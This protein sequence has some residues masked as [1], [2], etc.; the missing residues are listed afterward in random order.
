MSRPKKMLPVLGQT[1]APEQETPGATS[2]ETDSCTDDCC[3]ESEALPTARE[4]NPEVPGG[5]FVGDDFQRTVVRVEGMDCASCAATVEKRV[6]ALPGV[7]RATVN[8]A[9]GR[10]DA[11]HDPGLPMEEIEEAVE[12]AGYRVVRAEGAES[13]PFWRTRRAALTGASAVLF[14]IGLA[15][16]LAGTS[17][18]LATGTYATAILVGGLPIFRAALA[19][20]RARQLDMNVLMG[21]ATI[22]AAGIGEWAEAASVVVLFSAG[23]ALQAYAVD[24]TRGAVRSLA[25]LA[26][27]EVLVRRGDGEV[28]VAADEVGVGEVV[29]VRPGERLAVDG[30]VIEGESAMDESPVTGEGVP[31]E[32]GPGAGVYSGALNGSGGLIVGATKRAGDSTLQRISRL[33]EEAQA[34]KAP[35]EQFVDRFSRVY[36]PIVVAVAVVLAV[37]PPLLGGGFGEWFYRALALL[38]I[39]CPCALVISTPVTVVAGI[40]AASRRGILVKG[41]AALEAAGRLGALA[42]DKTGTL[43]E[44]RPVLS[45]V[46]ALEG[47]EGEALALAAALER[48]SEHPLAYAILSAAEDRGGILPSVTGFRSF[49]G[50]GAT[51]RVDDGSYLIGSPRLFAER[52]VLLGGAAAAL[53][54]V[55][56]AG[57]TPVV[58]GVEEGG[59]IAVFGLADAVRPDARA[60]VEALRDSGIGEIVMLTGDAE[61]PARRVAESVGVDY[62]ARLLPE[63]KVEAVRGLVEKHGSAGMV[64]DGVND[65]PALAASSVGFAMG[66]AGTDVALETADVALMRD[67]LPKLAEAVRL[68]RAAEGIIKQNVLVSLLVKGMFVLLAPFGL[69]ALWAAVLADMGTSIAVTLNGLRLFKKRT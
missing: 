18:V 38:I 48:R 60:T 23:N 67:D 6:F 62:R 44:G 13:A 42:L 57:E 32:K 21:A 66:A 26:P 29:I 19:G 1:P 59:P 14:L 16:S 43:T 33:V 47:S 65:A 55:E 46:V 20:L 15:L 8:F 41:G 54:E 56:R 53:E 25:R 30:V 27:D 5:V 39:A 63:Q 51:G 52:E 68:S 9:A 61:A 40:G 64:G 69:V 4:A 34:E 22:G 31:V 12:G 11:E 37:V 2:A 10:L 17:Q 50:R 35:A 36:T 3:A 58:L 45:R 28:V 49:P 7:R 24:R